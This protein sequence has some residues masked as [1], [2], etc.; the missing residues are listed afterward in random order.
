[1]KL[2]NGSLMFNINLSKPGNTP[3]WGT[4]LGQSEKNKYKFTKDDYQEILTSM[5][6]TKITDMENFE[7]KLGKPG[8][9]QSNY[10]IILAS[11]YEKVYVNDIFIDNA[12]FTLVV[13]QE[14]VGVNGGRRTLKY[15]PKIAYKGI[16]N[17]E[18]YD[19]I[20]EKFEIKPEGAWYITDI[21]TKNQDELHFKAYIPD[22]EK[23]LTF[24]NSAERKK[25]M[26]EFEEQC[27][28]LSKY[29]WDEIA[30]MGN[31]QFAVTMLEILKQYMNFN[32]LDILTSKEKSLSTFKAYKAILADAEKDYEHERYY[33]EHEIVIYNKVYK[34]T[35]EWYGPD[36]G[37]S[38]DDRTP[39]M[40]FV[41]EVIKGKYG[42]RYIMRVEGGNNIVYYGVPGTGKSYEINKM[43]KDVEEA[44]KFR[45]TF[46]PEYSYNDFVGQLLPV[47]D[48]EDKIT[49]KFVE[50][51]F[52]QALKKAYSTPESMIY[53]I[54]EEMSRGNCAAIFGD[55]F[56]L[57]DRADSTDEETGDLKD[58]SSYPVNNDLI[59]SK[60]PEI[61]DNKIR[62]PSN[63]TIL[64][65][66]NTSDQNVFV[67]DTAFK[68]RFEW[69]YISVNP[70][71][72][73]D[74]EEYKNNIEIT[75]NDGESNF[76]TNWIY[77]Y[78][79]INKYIASKGKMGLGE[80]KQIGQ[81]FIKFTDSD[82]KGK[83]RD[84]LLQYLWFD[85]QE[86]SYA[87]NY[88]LFDKTID[89]FS[90]L[91]EFYDEGKKI[92][93]NEFIEELKNK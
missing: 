57:L 86:N 55:L 26:E 4:S 49:Y 70:V 2:D 58:W 85:V 44:N 21:T 84:K 43:L 77:L 89:S 38:K 42:E 91:Y 83:I 27:G 71:K 18:C 23:S 82:Y 41:K 28:D 81:F 76:S 63:F 8:A 1:M 51:P 56:Q 22:K 50:G 34:I 53:L 90:K 3:S 40:D 31:Q 69:K 92:F 5:V 24:A 93:S 65:T 13:S 78:Q 87:E 73:E 20:R 80:D 10:E 37:A 36:S 19:L 88:R 25:I 17:S 61:K 52:T 15:N 32:I 46:H 35:K 6:Y 74:S 68:R 67:I 45:V 16:A 29:N 60:I 72:K 33:S 62:I 54:I 48:E 75:L 66:I 79:T 7:F 9:D 64:G 12:K 39:F 30:K 59:A 14:L 47:T 11:S